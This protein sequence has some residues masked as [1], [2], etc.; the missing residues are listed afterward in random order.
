MLVHDGNRF[1]YAG[2][3]IQR[4]EGL[5][6]D[7]PPL[8]RE[9]AIPGF[10]DRHRHITQAPWKQDELVRK[11]DDHLE[12]SLPD[13]LRIETLI[14]EQ[15]T[16]MKLIAEETFDRHIRNGT[17]GSFEY[18]TSSIP[19]LKVVLE[20]AWRKGLEGR[21]KTGYVFM[22]QKVDSPGIRLEEKDIDKI[23]NELEGLLEEF[24][25]SIGIID[26]FPIA[27]SSPTREKLVAFAQRH[28]LS[29]ETHAN[30]SFGERNTHEDIYPG[31]RI[32]QV[33]KD[34]G[35]FKLRQVTLAHM[36]WTTEV[37]LAII[38]HAVESEGCQVVV[39]CCP[40]S[41]L[42]IES[43]FEVD[44][45]H[46]FN[47][48]PMPLREL[49][50]AEAVLT[51]GSDHGAGTTVNMAQE[52]CTEKD[53]PHRG[54]YR[55]TWEELFRYATVN[56]F[57]TLGVSDSDHLLQTGGPADYCVVRRFG[58]AFPH[59]RNLEQIVQ[60]TMMGAQEGPTQVVLQGN[61]LK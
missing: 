29:Y 9:V 4:P 2:P 23:L 3:S 37:D 49:R 17:L 15:P 33:L 8:S 21:I 59:E 52:V 10:V 44:P 31:Q 61:R 35:V 42:H 34:D 56:G 39:V 41:N 13:V 54:L 47:F 60:E 48:V 14:R 5:I 43:H 50:E 12:G 6:S 11:V 53:R 58:A 57:R 32:L 38:R 40:S 16:L 7:L 18:V 26:R 20:V 24:P 25:N 46:Q 22:D 1:S 55:P 28:D 27:V 45:G 30:E 51:L 36:L 19:A